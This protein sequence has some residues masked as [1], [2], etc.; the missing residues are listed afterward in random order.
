MLKLL[1]IKKS[2]VFDNDPTKYVNQFVEANNTDCYR[3]LFKNEPAI[4]NSSFTTLPAAI[5]V[6]YSMLNE[7]ECN[8]LGAQFE[9]S[10][11]CQYTPDVFFVSVVLYI[12]TFS[13]AML[14]RFFRTSRFFPSLVR[15]IRIGYY[16]DINRSY[17]TYTTT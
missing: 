2:N 5:P 3:C 9:F 1:E 4:G 11:R 15:I 10:K 14:F 7:Q 8:K 12:V 17:K 16:Y 13:L 6:N